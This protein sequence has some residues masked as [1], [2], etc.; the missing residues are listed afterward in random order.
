MPK[1]KKGI[2]KVERGDNVQK[3]YARAYASRLAKQ[4]GEEPE[5]SRRTTTSR[6]KPKAKR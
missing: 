4:V 6:K 2:R 5:V 3:L 1:R